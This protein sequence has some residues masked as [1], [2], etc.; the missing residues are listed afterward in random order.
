MNRTLKIILFSAIGT[1]LFWIALFSA[2]SFL[3]AT[4]TYPNCAVTYYGDD[5]TVIYVSSA[6]TNGKVVLVEHLGTLVEE[7]GK[8]LEDPGSPPTTNLVAVRSPLLQQELLPGQNIR[9]GIRT[10]ARK[11][12]DQ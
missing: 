2:L 11:K 10:T 4:T 7:S 9:L 3:F 8:V 12:S 5:F 6:Q 1:T